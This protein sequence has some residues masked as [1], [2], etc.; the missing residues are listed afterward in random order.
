MSSLK[1]LASKTSV[2]RKGV[3]PMPRQEAERLLRVLTGWTLKDGSIEKEFE[4]KS[5]L[6]GLDFAYSVGKIAEEQGHHPDI[7]IKWRR[8]RLILSTHSTKGL[9]E[10]DFIVAAK[11]ELRYRES[12]SD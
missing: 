2:E 5:Y 10:N 1:E 12:G 7:V 3:P 4:F 9:S 11:S 8:V 6:A